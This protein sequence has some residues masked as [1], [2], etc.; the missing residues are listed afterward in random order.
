MDGTSMLD[1]CIKHCVSL[2]CCGID[3]TLD[4]H[5]SGQEGYG[6]TGC[7]RPPRQALAVCR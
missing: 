1:R 6:S 5:G 2:Q 3:T 4:M 7:N